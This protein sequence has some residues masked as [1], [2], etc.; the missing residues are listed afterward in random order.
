MIRVAF[1]ATFAFAVASGDCGRYSWVG[2]GRV[3]ARSASA[4]ETPQFNRD[5]RPILAEH[6]FQCHGPDRLQRK[7][8]LRLDER[9]AAVSS[10]AIAPGKPSDSEL[11]K[12]ILST[13]ANESMPPPGRRPLSDAQKD[14][15][16]KWIAAGAE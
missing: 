9:D 6:C 12:R 2:H 8:D 1:A 16:Q 4:A 5:I 13:D 7:A 14:T 3:G 11:V 10:G 15:L